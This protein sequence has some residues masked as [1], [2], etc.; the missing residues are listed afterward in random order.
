MELV[1]SRGYYCE[2]S[3]R[4]VDQEKAAQLV[5]EQLEL[6]IE[7]RPLPVELVIL[8]LFALD[9]TLGSS[10]VQNPV[11]RSELTVAG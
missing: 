2:A 1:V 6:A 7:T 10:C 4:I 5:E 9:L 8:E 11:F 3:P